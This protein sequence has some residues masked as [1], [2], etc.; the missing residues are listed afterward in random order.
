[1]FVHPLGCFWHLPAVFQTGHG[2]QIHR[3]LC[4][5]EPAGHLRWRSGGRAL[6]EGSRLYQGLRGGY[7]AWR[8]MDPTGPTEVF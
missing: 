4:G 3:E 8:E 7:D 2:R 6:S 5:G 1:M